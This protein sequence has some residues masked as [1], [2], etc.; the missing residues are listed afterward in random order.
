MQMKE[1]L[2]LIEDRSKAVLESDRN[3][4]YLLCKKG[5]EVTKDE[6]EF[7]GIVDG[8]LKP[9]ASVAEQVAK[10]TVERASKPKKKRK[11]AAA[12]SEPKTSKPKDEEPKSEQIAEPEVT[13]QGG[14]IKN[15]NNKEI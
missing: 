15:G 4:K 13:R 9:G 6:A 14:V 1:R 11:K 8:Y 12:K 5:A 3:G 7:Y 2:Y 10:Q